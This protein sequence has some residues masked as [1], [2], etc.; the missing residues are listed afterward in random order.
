MNR[1]LL[2][3]IV[4]LVAMLLFLGMLA[5]GYLLRFPLPPGT[6]K[7]LTLWGLSRHQWGDVHFWIS[8][9][10]LGVMLFHLALHWNWIVTVLGKR[11]RLITTS[12]PSLVRSAIW[13][14]VFLL[15]LSISFGWF[16]Q[17]DV[18][19]LAQPICVS[20]ASND[21]AIKSGLEST[22][23]ASSFSATK[24]VVWSDVYPIFASHCLHCHGPQ[25]SY[26]GFRADR[27]ESILEHDGQPPYVLPGNSRQSPLIAIVSGARPSMAMA[28][29][30]KLADD[31]VS[32]IARWIDQGAK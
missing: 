7:S 1:A 2:N 15:G 8:L 25:R 28:A 31:D 18:K 29:S 16:A 26:A 13:S 12:Q 23:N 19:T 22:S 27:L 30:H 21:C 11:C 14:I 24:Q 9:G 10:L 32:R 20:A 5:T 4:D 6:N 3:V 17:R